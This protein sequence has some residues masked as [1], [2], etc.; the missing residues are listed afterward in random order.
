MANSPSKEPETD[1]EPEEGKLNHDGVSIELDPAVADCKLA[2]E[3]EHGT[4]SFG[5]VLAKDDL[6]AYE[7]T[8]DDES[9]IEELTKRRS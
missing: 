3:R 6:S 1:R 4:P 8:G 9:E 7:L 5:A 2:E